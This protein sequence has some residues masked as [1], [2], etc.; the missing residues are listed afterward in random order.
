MKAQ[1]KKIAGIVGSGL[2]VACAGMGTT[3]AFANSGIDPDTSQAAS[4]ETAQATSD[5]QRPS[6]VQGSFSFTQD[7][8]TSTQEIA[9]N[10]GDS[11]KYLC[12]NN[13]EELALEEDASLNA[14][15][16]VIEV[17]GAVNRPFAM[18]VAELREDS[19]A[20]KM[21][22]GCS[23]AGNPVDGRASVNAEVTGVSVRELI[24]RAGR[25]ME[26]NT[27]VFTSADGYEVALPLDYVVNRYCPIVFDVNGSPINESIGGANQLWLGST[28]ARYF[29]R[30]IVSITVESR[31]EIPAVPGSE[32]SGDEYANLP[33]IG[34]DFG[35][36]VS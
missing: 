29:A 26:A 10:M 1:T 33:N 28:S 5:A 23:C 12:G 11:P 16:W 20:Q 2:M 35:G 32:D 14:D 25:T 4:C 3:T 27:V 7:A 36:T 18:T 30:N 17:K 22:M 24:Q 34:I 15:E 9:K 19:S 6:E 8:V 21:V 31:E 13:A